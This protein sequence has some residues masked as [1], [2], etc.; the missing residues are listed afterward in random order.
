M[1]SG[2]ASTAAAP[3][4]SPRGNNLSG[5]KTVIKELE[6]VLKKGRHTPEGKLDE[7]TQKEKK[8]LIN[9]NMLA[10][11]QRWLTQNRDK[12]EA[13][14][15][16]VGSST[17]GSDDSEN[18]DLPTLPQRQ[19]LTHSCEP[20]ISSRIER[21]ESIELRAN[22]AYSNTNR[23]IPNPPRI[24]PP[25]LTNPVAVTHSTT[26]PSARGKTQPVQKVVSKQENGKKDSS[27]N[28]A[29]ASKMKKIFKFKPKKK[30]KRRTKK[31]TS[32]PP[33]RASS[34]KQEKITITSGTRM[35]A[36]KS[37]SDS[38][39]AIHNVL[40][41]TSS[42]E[43][44]LNS[45]STPIHYSLGYQNI[46]DNP[47]F[48]KKPTSR[49]NTSS[50]ME[51]SLTNKP[52]KPLPRSSG[53]TVGKVSMF[54]MGSDHET[55]PET[56]SPS[57][58]T[59]I[60]VVSPLMPSSPN[61]DCLTPVFTS[62]LLIEDDTTSFV[63]KKTSLPEIRLQ[64][65]DDSAGVQKRG[66]KERL[67][68]TTS[69]NPGASGWEIKR[70]G[71]SQKQKELRRGVCSEGPHEEDYVP[72]S[73][74]LETI[75]PQPM[76]DLLSVNSLGNSRDSY[77]LSAAYLKLLPSMLEQE[78]MSE[79]EKNKSRQNQSIPVL[80]KVRTVPSLDIY[81]TK[82][83]DTPP[84]L[85]D[86][87]IYH[88]IVLEDRLLTRSVTPSSSSPTLTPKQEEQEES[89]KRLQYIDVTVKTA[90]DKKRKPS[91]PKKFK[92]QMIT[93]DEGCDPQILGKEDVGNYAAKISPD[94]NFSEQQQPLSTSTL[95]M[96]Q[97]PSDKSDQ[98]HRY[99]VNRNSLETMRNS[100]EFP[101]TMLKTVDPYTGK[102]IWHEYVEI[103]EEEIDQIATSMGVSPTNI[104]L[105]TPDDLE[106]S[107]SSEDSRK[108]DKEN[109]QHV[110][111]AVA[112]RD[113]QSSGNLASEESDNSTTEGAVEDSDLSCSGSTVSSECKYVFNLDEPPSIP[114]RPL[115][116]ETLSDNELRSSGDYSY[117]FI[118]D[119]GARWM[120]PRGNALPRS[121]LTS[122]RETCQI[123]E[124]NTCTNVTPDSSPVQS[125]NSNRTMKETAA[126]PPSLPPKT[127]SLMREQKLTVPSK[128]NGVFPFL[129]QIIVQTKKIKTLS[130]SALKRREPP[131]VIPYRDHQMM[132]DNL[133]K[134]SSSSDYYFLDPLKNEATLTALGPENHSKS[135]GLETKKYVNSGGTTRSPK[136]LVRQRS[137]GRRS[138]KKTAGKHREDPK[139]VQENLKVKPHQRAKS[140][141]QDSAVSASP[142]AESSDLLGAA[143][144]SHPTEN[145]AEEAVKVKRGLNMILTD[146]GQL[147]N[148]SKYSEADLL[149]AIETH[150]KI[151]AKTNSKLI[152]GNNMNE[153]AKGKDSENEDADES[154]SWISGEEPESEIE[155]DD[156]I[157]DEQSVHDYMNQSE[158]DDSDFELPTKQ[159]IFEASHS[160]EE[161]SDDLEYEEMA[162]LTTFRTNNA[163]NINVHSYVNLEFGTELKRYEHDESKRYSY[164]DMDI[165]SNLDIAP[166]LS[167]ALTSPREARLSVSPLLPTQHHEDHTSQL[168]TDDICP[169]S[170]LPVN[171]RERSKSSAV[172]K[173][174]KS[175]EN[176]RSSRTQSNPDS[177]FVDAI[178]AANAAISATDDSTNSHNQDQ[179]LKKAQMP[180]VSSKKKLLKRK[181]SAQLS[182]SATCDRTTSYQ[183]ALQ[184]EDTHLSQAVEVNTSRRRLS[185]VREEGK[186][187]FGMYIET[188]TCQNK[189]LLHIGQNLF[190]HSAW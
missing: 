165:E 13:L 86:N 135:L 59:N 150:L 120:L 162:S 134:E 57:F 26:A 171:L 187:Y 48:T 137:H 38:N 103:D 12:C 91:V 67:S 128:R 10:A 9:E 114:P 6:Q 167:P 70:R 30:K 62:P 7:V 109:K 136:K 95:E 160:G 155:I 161:N 11:R 116:F 126:R 129:P 181:T 22:R 20:G 154:E 43:D 17:G 108:D 71:S 27:G 110:S 185:A 47:D 105:S 56:P 58:Q 90:A 92:Y 169:T 177:D 156:Q 74:I 94:D 4:T 18:E 53:P 188:S 130:N 172:K 149:A 83:C 51:T 68:K 66:T 174:T 148:N 37:M 141:S 142:T 35:I 107:T 72:N 115:N 65:G 104:S 84:L 127:D 77:R 106:A 79:A 144:S 44:E 39:L 101:T 15:T 175:S 88:E 1:Y 163:N 139:P 182:D 122:S 40:V 157:A 34:A 153:S 25:S 89:H 118:P 145:A 54:C 60:S 183:H 14:A 124:P 64:H 158:F 55:D 164:V 102:I 85:E 190:Y 82:P 123:T 63:H 23:I 78:K 45:A 117:V 5:R 28:N 173:A 19:G 121:S 87:Q 159:L 113:R 119:V 152:D 81:D 138:Y 61:S 125:R 52:P 180:P 73:S 146:L 80:Q 140:G 132:K 2:S 42:L 111:A 98:E 75:A 93:I 178:L 100:K 8:H 133:K 186:L 170:S 31:M 179:L 69:Y 49:S 168:Q 151:S 36:Q 112:N 147:L 76:A 41:S 33:T 143:L 24:P 16:A 189:G 3:T 131:K 32:I 21:N 50:P 99:Y 96:R 46:F 184:M 29:A 97:S 166:R 176:P